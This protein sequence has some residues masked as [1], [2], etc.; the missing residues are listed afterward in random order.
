[1]KKSIE[2]YK[3]SLVWQKELAELQ[4]ARFKKFHDVDTNVKVQQAIIELEQRVVELAI[5]LKRHKIIWG[6]D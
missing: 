1:M 3:N 2:Q 6:E 4:I 5:K